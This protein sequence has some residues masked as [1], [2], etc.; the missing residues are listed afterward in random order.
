MAGKTVGNA[1]PAMHASVIGLVASLIVAGC[2]NPSP[3]LPPVPA[4][5]VVLLDDA[6]GTTGEVRVTTSRGTTVLGKSRQ[7]ARFAGPAGEI[8]EASRDR[9]NH[10]FGAALAAM[11]AR[12]VSFLLYFAPGGTKLSPESE[13]EMARILAEIAAR[14][15]PDISVIGHTDTTGS[16]EDNE[17][18][19][20]DRART[21]AESIGRSTRLEAG[22]ITVESHGK[23]NLLVATPNNTPEA[24]NRRVEVTI[25]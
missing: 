25:R 16:N 14:A 7:A 21:V 23:K 17:R 3:T 15:S 2:A 24:R 6:D 19:S 1:V 5:Y 20:L 22:K 11:P 18:L 13:G 4:S 8:F 10:D 12:P 9:I